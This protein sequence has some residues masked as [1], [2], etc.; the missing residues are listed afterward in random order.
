[1]NRAVTKESLRVRKR[2]SI[3]ARYLASG[4]LYFSDR[5]DWSA[6]ELS[7]ASR[8]CRSGRESAERNQSEPDR[9]RKSSPRGFH[10]VQPSETARGH[11]LRRHSPHL[12]CECTS[13]SF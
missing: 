8:S 10:L 9:D 7:A 2:E 12:V 6:A 11:T 13:L 4:A 3:M 5:L 1:M